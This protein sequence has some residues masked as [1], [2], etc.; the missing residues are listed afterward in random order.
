MLN[1][2]KVC[3][4]ERNVINLAEHA[5]HASV[6]DSRNQRRQKICQERWLLLE[7]ESKSLVITVGYVNSTSD[8]Y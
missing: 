6:V 5:D 7:I 4:D 2:N 1:S 3:P 8:R